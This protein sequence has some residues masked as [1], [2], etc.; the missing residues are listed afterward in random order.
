MTFHQEVQD[1]ISKTFKKHNV[2][3]DP[4]TDF[5]KLCFDLIDSIRLAE[6]N[7]V[8]RFNSI[9]SE[10]STPEGAALANKLNS[11]NNV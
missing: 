11:N 2:E 4:K 1:L 5:T 10:K 6:H 8:I 7:E 9:P 3:I